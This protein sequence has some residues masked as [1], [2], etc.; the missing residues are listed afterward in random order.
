MNDCKICGGCLDC[1]KEHNQ[2][3]C[4]KQQKINQE[5]EK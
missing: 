2:E 4:E 3:S 1:D 5:V